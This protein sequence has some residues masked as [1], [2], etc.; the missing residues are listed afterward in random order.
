MTLPTEAHTDQTRFQHAFKMTF[1]TGSSHCK[2]SCLEVKAISVFT[3]TKMSRNRRTALVI[4]GLVTAIAAAF[5][6]IFVYPLT[7]TEEYSE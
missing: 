7:H 4:G 1:Y 3:T 6:P 2:Q 5:Y